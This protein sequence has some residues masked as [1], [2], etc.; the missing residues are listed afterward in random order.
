MALDPKTGNIKAYVGGPDYRYFM[1][2]MVSVGKR[3]VGS[4]IKPILYTLAMQEGLAP[5][6]KV[7]NVAQTFVLPDGTTWTPRNSTDKR[8]NEWVTLKWGLANSVNN[9][10]GWVM[11]QFTPEAVAQMAHKMG[12]TSFIDP[13]PALFLGLPKFP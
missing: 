6:Q 12:I 11:K 7:L 5:C 1:Y 3:Q 4:T 8:E 13:V 10:S 2:D 9:I